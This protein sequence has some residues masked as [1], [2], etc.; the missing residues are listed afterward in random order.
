MEGRSLASWAAPSVCL[1]FG[2]L[3][4]TLK[5]CENPQPC[6]KDNANLAN[7]VEVS[8]EQNGPKKGK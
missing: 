1:C 2:G 8:H 6:A 3:A 4:G 5:I 7:G